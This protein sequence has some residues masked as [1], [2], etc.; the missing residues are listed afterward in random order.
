MNDPTLQ[1]AA[2]KVHFLIEARVVRLYY[3]KGM[4][5]NSKSLEGG[6]E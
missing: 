2:G 3:G 6:W 5:K 1:L 4:R